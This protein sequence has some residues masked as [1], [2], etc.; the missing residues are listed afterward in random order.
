MATVDRQPPDGFMTHHNSMLWSAAHLFQWSKVYGKWIDLDYALTVKPG[1]TIAEAYDR[2]VGG[3]M[4]TKRAF[5][6]TW[7]DT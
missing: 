2:E 7:M 1:E 6:P 3:P 5:F 4:D